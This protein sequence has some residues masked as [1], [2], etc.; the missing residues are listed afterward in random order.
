VNRSWA[1]SN[2]S[3]TDSD[4]QRCARCGE[5]QQYC[6]GHTPFIPNPTLDLPPAQPRVPVQGAIPANHVARFNLNRA[7]ATALASRLIN[8]LEQDHKDPT[9]VPPAYDYQGEFTRVLAEGLGLTQAEV[10]E[11]LGLRCGGGPQRGQNQGGRPRQV[12]NANHPANSQQ[13]QGR[14]PA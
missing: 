13:M 11:G 8:A 6:H 2:G 14:Q 12:P 9:E 10:T 5:Q 4:L 7:Q 1:N 3:A